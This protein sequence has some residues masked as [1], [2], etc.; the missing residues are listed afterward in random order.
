MAVAATLGGA[1]P[2][3]DG[4]YNEISRLSRKLTNPS[5]REFDNPGESLKL[6]VTT[7]IGTQ[8][9]AVETFD[10]YIKAYYA[11]EGDPPVYRLFYKNSS[12]TEIMISDGLTVQAGINSTDPGL[13]TTSYV[14]NGQRIDT[15]EPLTLDITTGQIMYN[16]TTT[17]G[18]MKLDAVSGLNVGLI[19]E[20]ISQV[21][22]V[23]EAL[24]K[25]LLVGTGNAEK[26]IELRI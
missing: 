14:L 4:L 1:T 25:V 6:T 10:T 16:N 20:R 3:F 2:N 8:N 22:L 18:I 7:G 5:A 13:G 12:N 9:E 15:T 11:K 21:N 24:N 17:L 23:I 26:G 19:N